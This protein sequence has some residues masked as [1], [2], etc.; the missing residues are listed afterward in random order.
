MGDHIPAAGGAPQTDD[1]A[2]SPPIVDPAVLALG[3]GSSGGGQLGQEHRRLP[4]GHV[5]T[6][7]GQLLLDTARGFLMTI[8]G[9][10][11]RGL[12]G[13]QPA[14]LGGSSVQQPHDVG[15]LSIGARDGPAAEIEI[16]APPKKHADDV[17]P[18][19]REQCA[20]IREH[21]PMYYRPLLVFL[22]HT[23]LR[24]GEATGLRWA[25]IDLEAK[26]RSTG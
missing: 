17:R 18:P 6:A 26:P 9:E 24:W 3:A 14:H 1:L 25:H 8:A 12:F 19:T 7:G 21:T 22:E 23:G 15:V 20:L 10:P 4:R 13:V 16:E 5:A 2:V 11:L